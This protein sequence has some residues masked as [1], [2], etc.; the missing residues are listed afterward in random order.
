M[1]N[2]LDQRVR[3]RVEVLGATLCARFEGQAPTGATFEL[4]TEERELPEVT[5]GGSPGR[6][7]ELYRVRR[8]SGEETERELVLRDVYPAGRPRGSSP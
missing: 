3:L 1:R 8:A 6:E 7:I 4:E 5:A 2:D